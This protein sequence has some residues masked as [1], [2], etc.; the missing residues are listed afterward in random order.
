MNMDLFN[1]IIAVLWLGGG[2]LIVVLSLKR[3]N[4]PMTYMVTPVVLSKLEKRDWLRILG[5]IVI[6]FAT[7]IILGPFLTN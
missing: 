5:L 2:N 1:I 3:Q 6:T 4:L 7:G